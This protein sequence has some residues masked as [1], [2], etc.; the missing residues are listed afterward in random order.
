MRPSTRHSSVWLS[1]PEWIAVPLERFL[2]AGADRSS[3]ERAIIVRR[4]RGFGLIGL[5]VVFLGGVVSSLAHGMPQMALYSGVI[6]ASM[7]LGLWLGFYQNARFINP[8]A[9][10]GMGIALLGIFLSSI[11][12][13]EGSEIS[14]TFPMVLIL[15][16]MYVLG[17]RAAAF[18]TAASIAAMGTAIVVAGVPAALEAD[19][20]SS[21]VGV[22]ASRAIV[23]LAV[24]ALAAIER[25]FADRQTKELHYMARHD[26]LTGL[27]NR[28]AL[29]ERL[30]EAIARARRHGRRL[31]VMVV[32]LDGF[33]AVND[34][35]GHA[36]GDALL[37]HLGERIALRTRSTDTASRTGGDEFAIL[38]DDI[39]EDKQVDLFAERLLMALAR[40]IQT[41]RGDFTLGASVGVTTL[42]DEDASPD[43]ILRAADLAMY[44]AKARGGGVCFPGASHRID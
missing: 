40:P 19:S 3:P 10:A 31:A 25:L 23:M 5:V 16:S 2:S 41:G 11:Y 32:D 42:K 13:G 21:Y 1:L 24:F 22:F 34:A 36:V 15:A 8:V 18:W 29:D 20:R 44:E 43:S 35:H 6:L 26:S 12:I 37:R 7:A 9:H 28:R 30:G 27:Y 38:L 39:V 17:V 14:A 4:G 33:K